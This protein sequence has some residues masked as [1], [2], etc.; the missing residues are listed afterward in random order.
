MADQIQIRRDS[1]TNWT[2]ADTLLAQGEMGYETDTNKLKV[3][4]G[5]D[6]WSALEY[7]TGDSSSTVVTLPVV[8]RTGQL[9]LPTDEKLGIPTLPVFTR[10][11][12]V[13]QLP[14]QAA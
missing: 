5:D 7:L 8:T 9:L 10:S 12:A 4:N 2:D 6:P 11:G 14:L 1:S 13:V 3:G